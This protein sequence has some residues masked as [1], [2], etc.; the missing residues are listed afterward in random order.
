MFFSHVWRTYPLRP[1][2]VSWGYSQELRSCC[3]G[4]SSL[5]ERRSLFTS[6]TACN[7][8]EVCTAM[9]MSKVSALIRMLIPTPQSC[10]A[11]FWENQP[12]LTLSSHTINVHRSKEVNLSPVNIL[13][14]SILWLSFLHVLFVMCLGHDITL[15][16]G[17]QHNGMIFIYIV[18]WSHPSSH[19]VEFFFISL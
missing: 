17:I 6:Y 19:I 15:V 18:R 8:T 5:L 10:E 11:L 13:M 14:S 3:H 12:Y 1:C 4:A 9:T 16:S 7:E 2:V